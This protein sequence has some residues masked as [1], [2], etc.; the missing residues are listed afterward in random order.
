[1]LNGAQA[2]SLS[3]SRY[4]QYYEDGEWHSDLSSDIGRIQRQN[5]IISA[6]LD[7]AKS[8]YNPLR[9]NTL[10]TSLVHDFSKDNGLSPNDLFS[11]AERYHAF[12]GS[13]LQSYTL[14]T[15]PAQTSGGS[16]VEVVEPDAASAMITQFL[17]GPFG[18]ITTPPL[19]AYGEAQT[20][21]PPTTVP[22]TAPPATTAPPKSSS[23]TTA[24]TAPPSDIPSFDPTPC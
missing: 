5:L 22:T 20:L 8:T 24:T 13:Q 10:L 19:D 23:G 16:D 1:M 6:T 15:A 21:T 14:P 11:L 2:L 9:L 12:S 4:F 18:T 7:K 17:G 3:R